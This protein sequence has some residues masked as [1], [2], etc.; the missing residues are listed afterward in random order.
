M[1]T[2]IRTVSI[3]VGA[4]AG[5]INR[6]LFRVPKGTSAYGGITLTGAYI[7]AGGAATSVL[8]LL[9]L[10]TALGTTIAA[11]G[12]IGTLN[13]TLVANVQQALSITTAYQASGTWIGLGTGAGTSLD[14]ATIL[15]IEYVYGK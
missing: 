15:T 1:D 3:T 9:N 11:G 5:T 14:A 7:M 13:A 6:P 12:T 2:G 8:Q 10:G 4:Q